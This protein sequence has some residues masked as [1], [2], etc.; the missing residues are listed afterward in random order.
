MAKVFVKICGFTRPQ[1]IIAAV[2]ANVSMIGLNFYSRSPRYLTFA[3]AQ[4]L[5]K[6]IP[7]TVT[8]VGLYVDQA[9]EIMDQDAQDLH[10][11]AL[12]YYSHRPFSFQSLTPSIPAFR[13][14]QASDLDGIR[15]FLAA[16]IEKPLAVLIDSYVEG[17]MGGTGHKAPWD[18]LVD[19]DPGVPVILAG[20]LTPENVAE[21][22]KLVRPW[23]VDVASGVES[24]PGIKDAGKMRL[25]IENAQAAAAGL[26]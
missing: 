8:A 5:R 24:A 23:G 11:R 25:F 12:Q 15:M 3:A 13:V 10:L 2:E 1:D 7:Q 9:A 16:C 20:G 18:L 21:A 6:L 17:E 14:R 22:V 4:S 26:S 19:F